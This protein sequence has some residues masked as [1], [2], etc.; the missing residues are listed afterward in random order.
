MKK[1]HWVLALLIATLV[2]TPA[3]A[4]P[5]GDP[6]AEAFR[7]G[8][9]AGV[10]TWDDV[11]ERA[12]EEGTVNWF[13]WGGSDVL[14]VWIDQV[15]A[16]DLAELGITLETSRIPNTR[17]AV[18]LVLADA[19]AG[20][21][22][23]QGTVDAIWIN[24]EN[25]LT[26]SRQGLNFGSVTD[27]L[28]NAQYFFLDPDD[29]RSGANLFDFGFPNNMEEVPWSGGQYSC[30]IDTARL[31]REDAPTDYAELEAWMRDNP[32][33][34]SYIRPPHFNGN[35]FVQMVHYARKPEG[36]FAPFQASAD[37]YTAEEFA[38]L[39]TPGFEYL[40]RIEPFILGG[41]GEDGRRGSPI[42]PEGDDAQTALFANGEIDMACEFGIY[43]VDTA[44]NNGDY[45]ESVEQVIFPSSGQIKNKNFIGIPLNSP[46]P[47]A[48]L[49]LA[50]YLASPANQI[51]KLADIGFD[52]GVDVPLLSA[53]DQAAVVEAAPD[54]QGVTFEELGNA[55]VPDTNSTLVDIIE[56]VWIEY[57]ERQSSDSIADIVG[58]AF[59]AR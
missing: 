20:R 52:L 9:L 40:R 32:G 48:A 11:L 29:P 8:F 28:P 59:E 23:G 21:G 35:T 56:T 36:S 43:T 4:Q 46:N 51:S 5:S 31:S 27:K 37:T 49:V 26:L 14:N 2:F 53:E 12:Q 18:D 54:L 16:P 44:I 41:G 10:L 13:H 39:V 3:L 17:D 15:V 57:I 42:Y 33:R 7:D 50:N 45:A 47:A 58:A 19:A 34:F 38:R 30:Y 22:V 1:L 6:D 25:F 24:G 55:A